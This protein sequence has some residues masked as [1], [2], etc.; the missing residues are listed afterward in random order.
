[1]KLTTITKITELTPI[2]NADKIER[3]TVLGWHCVVKKGLHNVGDAVCFLFP[4]TLVPRHFLEEGYVGDEKVRLKTIKMRG[5]FSAGLIVPLSCINIDVPLLEGADIGELIGVEKYEKPAPAKLAGDAKGVFPVQFVSKT[6]EDNYRSNPEAFAEMKSLCDEPVVI[7]SK[8]DGTSATFIYTKE[9]DTFRACSRNLELKEGESVY[10]QMAQKYDLERI[11]KN[12]DHDLALQGEIIGEGINGNNLKIRGQELHIFLI[13]DISENRWL[14]WSEMEEFCKE[15]N[16]KT[17]PLLKKIP[18]S[19]LN[20]S[21]IQQMADS[22]KYPCG[23]PAEGI[24]FRSEKP[25]FSE[26]LGK[27]WLSLK[28][29]NQNYKD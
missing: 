25:I 26:T 17:V 5:Q 7:T 24:V 6:D 3:A 12:R 10:W 15:N 8:Q 18:A 27:S 29:I 9:D 20:E 21:E 22:L 19:D 4:D 1:M 28:A 13:K 23:S 16:L 11:M 14:S 2:P